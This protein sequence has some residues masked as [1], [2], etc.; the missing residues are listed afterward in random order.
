MCQLLLTK[1]AHHSFLSTGPRSVFWYFLKS[2][3]TLAEWV[4]SLSNIGIRKAA[5]L[6]EP[7]NWKLRQTIRKHFLKFKAWFMSIPVRAMATTSFPSIITG[8]VC[9]EKEIFVQSKTFSFLFELV[10]TALY[11]TSTAY[12]FV[13]CP[14]TFN[15]LRKWGW[16]QPLEHA[17]FGLK[18]HSLSHFDQ[19]MTI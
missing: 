13:K 6:P 11:L 17:D 3:L 5:V 4:L 15:L 7:D 2:H 19:K 1:N 16:C 8:I 12:C 14:A 10:L 18:N 9:K